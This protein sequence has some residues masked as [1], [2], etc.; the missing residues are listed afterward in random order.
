MFHK[1]MHLLGR[2]TGEVVTWWQGPHIMVGFKC[3]GCGKVSGAHVRHVRVDIDLERE[4]RKQQ[5]K[6]GG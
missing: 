6:G 2:N 1:L 3:H 4:V 5:K